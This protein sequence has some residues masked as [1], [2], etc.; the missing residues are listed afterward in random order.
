MKVLLVEPNYKNKYPPM[1]L[2]KIS[3]YHKMLGDEVRFVKGFNPE[4][5]EEVWDRIY[6]TTLFTFD[7]DTDVQTIN[8]Y[9][10]L[11]NDISDL[12][13]G[14]IMASLMPEKIVA[15]TGI[16]RSH[17][18]T[19]L[20]TD[21]SVVGDDNDINVD[22]LPLDY[23][24]LE[25]IDYKYP[26]GDNYF[27]Y[28]TRGCP[29]HCSFCA[30]PLL[31]PNFHV[32]NNIIDQ[33]KTIDEKYGPKQHL[34]LLDNN[35]LNTADL[36]G[37]VDDLCTAG[38]GRGAKYVDPGAYNIVMMRYKNGD[39]AEFLDK[40][41]AAYLES[42]K[43]RIKSAEML[44]TFLQVVID[45]EDAEDYAQYMLDHE[46]ELSP[47]IEKYRSKAKKARYLDFN[48][49]VDGRKINDEN[50]EQLARLAI[51]PLRIA[52]DDIKLKDV[53]CK[54][55]RTAHRHGINQISNYILFN[56]K[57]KPEDLYERLRVNIELNEELGIQIFSFPMKYSPINETDRTY[58]GVNWC[59]KSVR[60]ISAILQVTKG[61]VAAGSSFFYKAFGNNLEEYF[62]ILA[63]PRN[64]IMFRS[65]F[66]KN[67]TTAKWQALYRQLTDEQK[68][69]LMKLVSLNVSE[70]RNT[71]WP[72][73][74]V[75]ILEFYLL[76]YSRK[77]EQNKERYVQMSL[78]DD[79]DIV[80]EDQ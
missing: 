64:L 71:P 54:A 35:V 40:K 31:E 25:Q 1:G 69:R 27:A 79:S 5:D 29:N 39:R 18:L 12:Y 44:E 63:M 46:E 8:H 7:F 56:Y 30:V 9:K 16:D 34:L 68:D 23:D 57:D 51:H 66:E 24:I 32:T 13:V 62:E 60:A 70:L 6:V 45:A 55:V 15:S 2:M 42:F 73:D 36:K 20:F 4:V 3:T 41:M 48:Q 67:G 43:K 28:T 14:G 19:G 50:M 26:A 33:I 72:S 74:L 49:G 22:E 52:F 76:K 78:M 37:L 53:Y 21:T 47:I 75:D 17:I 38:F 10:L 11:V 80:V 61:V 59:K 58:I 77:T 65:Y